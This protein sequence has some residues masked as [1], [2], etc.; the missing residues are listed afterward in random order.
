M[1]RNDISTRRLQNDTYAERSTR[2]SSRSDALGGTG[3][4]DR[5]P[6][7]EPQ[8]VSTDVHSV[9]PPS[10]NRKP[11][12]TKGV[13][14]RPNSA[15][16]VLIRKHLSLAAASVVSWRDHIGLEGCSGED[17]LGRDTFAAHLPS[18]KGGP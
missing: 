12:T 9:G 15:G 11:G 1:L 7:L 16:A 4:G 14:A 6:R 17:L 3:W 10:S 13:H 2:R 8:Q 18:R 5:R